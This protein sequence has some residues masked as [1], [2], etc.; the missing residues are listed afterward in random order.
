MF[1]EEMFTKLFRD[2]VP[3][4]H[5]NIKDCTEKVNKMLQRGATIDELTECIH[6]FYNLM[7]DRFETSP[8]YKEVHSD[9]ITQLIDQTEKALMDKLYTSLF[10][11]IQSEEEERD[12]QLQKKIRNLN[13][14]MANHLDIEINMRHP[15]VEHSM[16]FGHFHDFLLSSG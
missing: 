9:Q 15:K 16:S 5:A 2:A 1:G 4:I 8:S 13:W 12:L 11:R 6:D 3:D 10:A 7:G 14:I